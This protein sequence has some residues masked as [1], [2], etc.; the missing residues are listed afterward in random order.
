MAYDQALAERIRDFFTD[1]SGLSEKKMFGGVGWTVFG[2]IAAGAHSD[3][4]LMIRCSR[5]DFEGIMAEPHTGGIM[6]G[7]KLLTG[8]VLVDVEALTAEAELSRWLSRGRDYATSLPK[9]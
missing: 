7:G 4:R 5:E 2:N 6:R 9:K 1:T 8:W 3:G